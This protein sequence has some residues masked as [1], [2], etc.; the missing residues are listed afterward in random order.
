MPGLAQMRSM[1]LQA[2]AGWRWASAGQ[3]HSVQAPD[4]Q[5]HS[6]DESPA[7]RSESLQKYRFAADE[8][9]HAVL[10]PG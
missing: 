8:L 7:C 6:W 3:T 9:L 1:G 5:C 4:R 2:P 10:K